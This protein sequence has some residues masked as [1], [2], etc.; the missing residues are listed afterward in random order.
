MKINDFSQ[1]SI[2][3][4]IINL[5]LPMTLAQLVNVLYNMVDRMYLGRLENG[6]DVLAGV[7]IC[8]P[9]I[10]IISAF[11]NFSSSGAV[12]LFSIAR[13]EKNEKEAFALLGNA[14]SMLMVFGMLIATVCYLFRTQ[15]MALFGAG[16]DV[17]QIGDDYLSI[18]LLGTLFV[19]V[20]TG[21]NGFIN[22]LGNGTVAMVSVLIG[23]IINIVLDPILIFQFDL[24]VKGAAIAS[25]IAQACSAT[26]ILWYLQRRHHEIYLAKQYLKL[27]SKRT[28]KIMSLGLSGFVMAFTNSLVQLVCNFSLSQHG[29]DIY[30]SIMTI[31]QSIRELISMPV[32]GVTRA[33]QP[34]MGYNYGA[35]CYER[36]CKCIRIMSVACISYTFL[37]WLVVTWKPEWFILLFSDD[38]LLIES[39]KE[40]LHLYYFGYFMMSFQ[41]IGQSTFVG[42]G[43]SKKAVF[44]SL[45]RK[46]FI[47]VPLTLVLPY[48]MN[49]GVNG[50]YIA[51]PISNFIGGGCCF[52]AM[53]YS[54]YIPLKRTYTKKY[55]KMTSEEI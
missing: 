41:F 53:I 36:V 44:F 22:A 7:G 50:V 13:G 52:V 27:E 47:V 51:E 33:S 28:L 26:Y 35:K 29:S 23:A 8:F 30:I 32:M 21:M 18:Y 24:G 20:S 48:V 2:F 39:A 49:L 11:A 6:S 45:F 55:D 9:I 46:A 38:A 43:E 5:A 1:G 37:L 14:F 16:N 31:I 19:M 42:L 3:K 10:M 4:H 54:V 34:I 12:P 17:L 15:F 25:V 40:A